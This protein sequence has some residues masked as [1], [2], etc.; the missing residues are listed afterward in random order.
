MKNA[1]FLAAILC[2][3]APVEASAGWGV[4]I[5]TATRIASGAAKAGKSAAKPLASKGT[6][7]GA[8]ASG[9]TGTAQWSRGAP[10]R[11]YG[12]EWSQAFDRLTFA[13]Y[14]SSILEA[15]D[16]KALGAS[17]AIIPAA[18]QTVLARA[19]VEE[20]GP[21]LSKLLQRANVQSQR[22][23]VSQIEALT[24]LSAAESGKRSPAYTLELSTGRWTF[25][26]TVTVGNLE[27]KA[28]SVNLYKVAAIS[29]GLTACTTTQA[30]IEAGKTLLS[31]K[32]EQ[33]DWNAAFKEVTREINAE[34]ER[35]LRD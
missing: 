30:C 17:P 15:V 18:K 28:G 8:G 1:V 3:V 32:V 20:A 7:R 6:W 22:A 31:R 5:K 14:R 25:N 13:K 34:A 35:A 11:P 16:E 27:I 29:A 26:R 23:N 2:L 33:S 21:S 10:V 9:R 12:A 4:V 24:R 19:F